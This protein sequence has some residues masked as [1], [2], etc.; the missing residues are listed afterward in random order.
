MNKDVL[1]LRIKNIFFEEKTKYII[2]IYQRNYAWTYKQISQ[3]I[4]DVADYK[5]KNIN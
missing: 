3:L 1:D 4:R 5:K 2:P